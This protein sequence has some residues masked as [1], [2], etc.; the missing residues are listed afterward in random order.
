MDIS[1]L[2]KLLALEAIDL[3]LAR[4]A[5]SQKPAHPQTVGRPDRR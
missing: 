3:S 5:F 1:S 2:K 4:P